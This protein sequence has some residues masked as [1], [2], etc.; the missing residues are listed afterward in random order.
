M[1]TYRQADCQR[2]I[3]SALL[4]EKTEQTMR[5]IY[6]TMLAL[7]SKETAAIFF[8]KDGKAAHYDYREYAA[9]SV[10]FAKRISVLLKEI[11]EE[12]VVGLKVHNCPEWPLLFWAL[13]MNGFTPILVDAR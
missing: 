4:L 6:E 1:K 2:F 10:S 9:K 12:S 8:N 7:H 11:P 5:D 13:L 3:D